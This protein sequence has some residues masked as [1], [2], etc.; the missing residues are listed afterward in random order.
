MVGKLRCWCQRTNA[1]KVQFLVFDVV[2][3]A[4]LVINDSV[5]VAYYELSLVPFYTTFETGPK[6][7]KDCLRS[8][9]HQEVNNEIWRQFS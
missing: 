2:L 1:T 4:L 6:H 5:R 3:A 7:H 8:W 9:K